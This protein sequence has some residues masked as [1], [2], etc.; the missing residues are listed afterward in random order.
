MSLKICIYTCTY[1][2]HK[3]KRKLQLFVVIWFAI[4]AG[5]S[6]LYLPQFLS[7]CFRKE[8][9]KAEESSYRYRSRS[10]LFLEWEA[11]RSVMRAS[12]AVAAVSDGRE[13]ERE[14]ERSRERIV[15]SVIRYACIHFSVY[16]YTRTY[17]PD[18]AA[19][20]RNYQTIDL[21]L[22]ELSLS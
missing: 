14:R 10:Q 12:V 3:W 19:G 1:V 16:R 4:V 2:F 6:F 5:F 8:I 9:L 15:S 20:K 21:G 13:K 17:I 7:N 22:K 11:L 18:W